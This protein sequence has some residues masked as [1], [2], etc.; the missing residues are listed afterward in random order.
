MRGCD[1][2]M[3]DHISCIPQLIVT[4]DYTCDY[5]SFHQGRP[6]VR[7][8]RHYGKTWCLP[9]TSTNTVHN[10]LMFIRARGASMYSQRDIL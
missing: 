10:Y 9:I 5:D 3:C 6:G 7:A 4:Y 1:I 2:D 8:S